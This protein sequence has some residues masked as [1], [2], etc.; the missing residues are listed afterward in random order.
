MGDAGP[1]PEHPQGRPDERH[2]RDQEAG[3]VS[4]KLG[5]EGALSRKA[6]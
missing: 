5:A 1:G 2:P 6:A 3:T 4:G